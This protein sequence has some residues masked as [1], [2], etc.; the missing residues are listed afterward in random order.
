MR[1]NL[2]AASVILVTGVVGITLGL[3]LGMVF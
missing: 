1:E 3:T 2:F